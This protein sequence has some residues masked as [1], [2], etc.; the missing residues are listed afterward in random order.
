MT[1]H[2]HPLTKEPYLRL[3]EPHSNIIITPHRRDQLDETVLRLVGLLN[4]PR[5]YQWLESTPYPYL[6]EH[7]EQWVKDSCKEIEQV[8]STLQGE[9]AENKDSY[10][11]DHATT[12]A[13]SQRTFFDV[14]P[15]TCI[16]EVLTADAETGAPLK[17]ILIGDI[18]LGR[19]TF[20][21]LGLA[22]EE[23]VEAQRKNNSLPA[24]DEKIA[25]TLGG[26]MVS[27]GWTLY[28]WCT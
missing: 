27:F 28:A 14:C 17:D 4:D 20:Y 2:Y 8:L 13:Q 7:G 25:W 10:S 22:S 23:R 24:G 18:K 3:P 9:L 11:S 15:F 21:E 1:V 16:R 26:K 12:D 5:I 6:R 19:Y